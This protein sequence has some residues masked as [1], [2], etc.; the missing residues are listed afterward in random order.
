MN[1]TE[2]EL[3]RS[4][5]V[6]L[7]ALMMRLEQRVARARD[8][9]RFY[10]LAEGDDALHELRANRPDRAS[11]HRSRLQLAL[12]VLCSR[13]APA[14]V[15]QSGAIIAKYKGRE[16]KLVA[17]LR[18]KYGKSA[19]AGSAPVLEAPARRAARRERP[20]ESPSAAAVNLCIARRGLV[21]QTVLRLRTM[22]AFVHCASRRPNI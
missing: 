21:V 2:H 8:H 14:N 4:T 20:E 1:A 13:V 15:K 16:A 19:Q 7:H 18:E 10:A 11:R 6:G 22:R 3:Y 17:F 9:N 5:I 12:E